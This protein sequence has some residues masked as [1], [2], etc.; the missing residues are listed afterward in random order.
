MAK[1]KPKK[2]AVELK[3]EVDRRIAES[4]LLDGDCKDCRVSEVRFVP[5]E[6]RQHYGANWHC[7]GATHFSPG[8]AGIVARYLAEV[9]RDFD[10]SDWD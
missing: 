6:A 7:D 4:T 8:C 9:R 2:T 1:P 10:C 3:A 5:P